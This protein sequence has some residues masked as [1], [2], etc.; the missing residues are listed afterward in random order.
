[1]SLFVAVLARSIGLDFAEAQALVLEPDGDRLWL[2]LRAAQLDR[3][4]IAR[5]ALT[6]AEADPRRDIEA[7]ADELD[8][9][10]VVEPADAR[11]A[12]A[13]ET[14][15]REFRAAIRALARSGRR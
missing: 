10:A 11:L 3:P 8:R 2:A 12:L 5:V 14:L 9:L 7:F 1:M 15:Q 6:L 13:P 4:T